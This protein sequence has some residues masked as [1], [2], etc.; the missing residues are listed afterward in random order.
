MHTGHSTFKIHLCMVL[1]T[2]ALE[3][4][5]YQEMSLFEIQK[6]SFLMIYGGLL[7]ITHT[8]AEEI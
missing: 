6:I 5:Q 8:E 2:Y 4:V 7:L 3:L 1:A